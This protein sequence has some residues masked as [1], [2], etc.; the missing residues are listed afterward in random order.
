LARVPLKGKTKDSLLA[1]AKELPTAKAKDSLL[2][3]VKGLEL[4]YALVLSGEGPK[5][6]E[7]ERE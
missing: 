2:A 6:Q 7:H 5:T 1:K 3:R 4:G